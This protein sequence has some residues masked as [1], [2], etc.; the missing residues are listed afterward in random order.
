VERPPA[1][2][3]DG[4]GVKRL[5][6][7]IGHPLEPYWSF[8][9]ELQIGRER[10]TRARVA[11]RAAVITKRRQSVL[12]RRPPNAGDA[13]SSDTTGKLTCTANFQENADTPSVALAV[14]SSSSRLAARRC[15]GGKRPR[16]CLQFG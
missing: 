6:M 1:G 5:H 16:A 11:E 3:V 10:Y 14:G 2:E 4:Q 9:R 7:R 12:E 8:L 15:V 13:Y